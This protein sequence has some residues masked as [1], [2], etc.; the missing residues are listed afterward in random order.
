[1][2]DLRYTTID[3]VKLRLTN[4]VQ[5][6]EG[7]KPVDGEVPNALLCQIIQDAEVDVEME[8]RSRYAI[9]FRSISKGTFL[10]LPESTIRALRK[11][12]DYRSVILVLGTDF[13][14]GTRV[15]GST[16]FEDMEKFYNDAINLALGRDRIGRNDKIDR[17]KVSPPLDDLK[18]AKSNEKADDGYRGTVMTVGNDE[19]AVDYAESQINDPSQSYQRTRIGRL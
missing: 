5:F 16:Y 15:E 11:A 13:G 2:S 17:F 4:K 14:R 1:M 10:S 18:L 7:E 8:L 19:S 6:Q 3:S 9:P 12:V